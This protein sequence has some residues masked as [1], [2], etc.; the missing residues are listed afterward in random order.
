MKKKKL[1]SVKVENTPSPSTI[2]TS[3]P[4]RPNM[5]PHGVEEFLKSLK[6]Y[7]NSDALSDVIVTCD[8]QEFKAHRVILSAHSKCFAK[9]LTGDWKESSER[10]IDIKDFD[11]SIVEAMLRFVY[12]F[13]YTNTYGTSSMVFDAQMWQIADKYDIPA[14]MA[15]SKKKFEIAVTTGWSMDDFSTAVAIVYESALPGLRDIVLV[16]TSKNIDK[17]L[18]KDG[19]SELMRT[20]PHFTADLVPFLC[21]TSS[22]SVCLYKCPSCGETFRGE[23]SQGKYYCPNCSSARSDWSNCKTAEA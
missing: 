21:G 3:T 23:F 12:S 11:P 6:E 20:T 16:T 19:F 14:L 5:A 9:A 22:K 10:K 4:L 17:L 18:D 2:S 7:H 15:E 13:E 8:G 1:A